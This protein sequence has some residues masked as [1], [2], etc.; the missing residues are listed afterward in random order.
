MKT[1]PALIFDLDGTLWDACKSVGESWTIVGRQYFSG[2]YE[3]TAEMARSQMGRTMDQIAASITLGEIEPEAR[4]RFIDDCF[5][6]E[7]EYLRNHPGQLFENELETL[8]KLK[9]AG[10]PLYIV[11][12]CQSGYI[13]NFLPLA[14]GLFLDHMCWSDTKKEKSVTIRALMERHGI[15]RAIYIGDTDQD[16][17]ATRDAGLPFCFAAYGFGT[18]E[19]YDGKADSFTQIF[20][21]VEKICRLFWPDETAE[22][23]TIQESKYL[24]SEQIKELHL[25]LREGTFD[26][27]RQT[28]LM[29]MIDGYVRENGTADL[30]YEKAMELYR[31]TLSLLSDQYEYSQEA[32]ALWSIALPFEIG[33]LFLLLGIETFENLSNLDSPMLASAFQKHNKA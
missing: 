14:P 29:T 5:A 3:I 8:T 27:P 16:G 33:A 25:F 15:E 28:E 18:T 32:K 19:L 21:E 22:S 4:K 24:N 17:V 13:E 26:L 30:E 20:D 7:V 11:S 12:N 6:Y 9:E 23:Q 10:Y 2:D 31:D 1:K